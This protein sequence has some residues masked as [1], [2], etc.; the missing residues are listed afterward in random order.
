MNVISIFSNCG[1]FDLE[2][3]CVGFD[4]P[5]ENK[6]DKTIWE[7]LKLLRFRLLMLMGRISIRA[8][9]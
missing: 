8:K 3:E 2:F 5:V 4:I 9:A 6:Y 1:E 7:I